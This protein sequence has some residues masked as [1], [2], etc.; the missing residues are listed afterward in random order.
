MRDRHLEK[1][2][3]LRSELIGIQ[4]LVDLLVA[5]ENGVLSFEGTLSEKHLEDGGLVMAFAFPTG[6]AHLYLVHVCKEWVHPIVLNSLIVG[7][8]KIFIS[9]HIYCFL[10]LSCIK[11]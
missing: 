8:I 5:T 7:L 6:V 2:D 11:S 9:L 10:I 4:K 1:L 3:V